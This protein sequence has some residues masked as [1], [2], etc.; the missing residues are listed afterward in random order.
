MEMQI[1]EVL[2]QIT[3]FIQ[4]EAKTETVVGDPFQLG[5]YSCIPVIKV[6]LGFGTG[7][8]EGDAPK[9]GH[10]MGAGAAAGMGIEPIGFLV[11]HG[12][13]ISFVSTKTNR[14]ISAAFEKVPDL[15]SKFID[16]RVEEK[17][18]TTEFAGN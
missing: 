3:Q 7:G 9:Q 10:G 4:S 18:K 14:G 11:S 6:G 1:K 13:D 8:G 17:S 2:K 16:S 15:L 5:E 12:N